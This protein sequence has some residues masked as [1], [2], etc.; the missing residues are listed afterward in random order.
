MLIPLNIG[1]GMTLLRL[2]AMNWMYK[3][4]AHDG[5]TSLDGISQFLGLNHTFTIEAEINWR[6][7]S[8]YFVPPSTHHRVGPRVALYRHR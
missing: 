1:H 7:Q 4:K 8:T 5:K 6:K 2:A 3:N